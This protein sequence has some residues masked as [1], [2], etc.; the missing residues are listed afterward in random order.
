MTGKHRG[1]PRSLL[2]EPASARL[3]Y[4]RGLTVAHPHLVQANEKLL[5]TIFESP[6]NSVVLVYGPTGVGKTTLCM[7]A[8]Q[9]LTERFIND[10]TADAGRIP[11]ASVEA[12]APE[13]GNFSWKEHF[14]VLLAQ[15]DEPL[16]N[17][18]LGAAGKHDHAPHPPFTPD[19]KA[20]GSTYR[21][22]VEQALRF[23]NPFAVLIDEAQHLAKMSSGRRL[24]DQLDVIKSIANRSSTVHVLFGTYELLGFRNL[25]GQLSRRSVDIHFRRY[26]AEDDKERQV[27]VNVL[28]SFEQHL[29]FSEPPDLARH[30]EFLYERSIGCVGILKEWLTK[31]LSMALKQKATTLTVKHLE[32]HAAPVTQCDRVLSDALEGERKLVETAES[33]S[34]LRMLLGLPSNTASQDDSLEMPR[35]CVSDAAPGDAGV[36]VRRPARRPGV[37]LPVRDAIGKPE[38][39]NA[40][41]SNI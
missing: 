28:R 20:A 39:A 30:W 31:A 23:R 11:V 10:L 33:R 35:E 1:F 8:Q 12:M 24:L 38:F 41:S 22:A 15:M 6:P 7:K 29:P 19:A 40:A 5:D 25:S 21:H 14:K 13:S 32:S 16:I 36:T 3:Q 17:Y 27:F 2:E 4:F 9:T 34:R 26:L 37:R 18:K